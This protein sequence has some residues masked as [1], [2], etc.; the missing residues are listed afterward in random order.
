MSTF[1]TILRE[2]LIKRSYIICFSLRLKVGA[3]SAFLVKEGASLGGGRFCHFDNPDP[4]KS[5]SPPLAPGSLPCP[6]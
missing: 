5:L 3:E 1:Y 6:S 2:C 4:L